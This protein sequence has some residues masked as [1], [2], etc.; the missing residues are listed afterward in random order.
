M[1]VKRKIG[2]AFF[3]YDDGFGGDV[4]ITKG[5]V[6]MRLTVLSLQQFVAESIRSNEM[7][8]VRRMKPEELLRR[9]A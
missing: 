4:E 3:A 8:R 9:L 7:D 5:D 6:T 1:Q 2:A